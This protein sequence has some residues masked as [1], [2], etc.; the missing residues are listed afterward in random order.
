MV[1]PMVKRRSD[2][3]LHPVRLRIVLASSGRDVTTAD[4]AADLP[5]VPQASLYRHIG[6]LADAG[7]LDVVTERPVR[8]TV[9]RTYR[10][11]A[12]AAAMTAEDVETMTPQ[13][14]DE[15][16]AA[17]V[18]ALMGAFG[19]YVHAPGAD[20]SIDGVGYRQVPLWL[21]D[22]ELT[23][24]TEELRAVVERYTDRDPTHPRRRRRTH[25]TII[26]PAPPPPPGVLA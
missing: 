15:A 26:I 3:V 5:D 17:F 2:L 1:V 16:F 8:G 19:R 12:G 25:T 21:D 7:I 4:L 22:A 14:H 11:A 23:D 13:Q 6:I 20:P 18:G 24:M 10:L 9:E